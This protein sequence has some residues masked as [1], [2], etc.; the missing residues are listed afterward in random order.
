MQ[1]YA[2]FLFLG[3]LLVYCF[4][5]TVSEKLAKPVKIFALMLVAAFVVTEGIALMT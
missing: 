3:A 1:T 2:N 5:D 4:T